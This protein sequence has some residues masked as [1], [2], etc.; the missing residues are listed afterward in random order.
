MRIDNVYRRTARKRMVLID[1]PTARP[2][3]RGALGTGIAEHE[4]GEGYTR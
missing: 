3:L 4:R 2:A 1:T